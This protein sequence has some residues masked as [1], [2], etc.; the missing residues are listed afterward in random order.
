MPAAST[1]T[2]A[3]RSA[4]SPAFLTGWTSFVAGFSGAIAAVALVLPF[5]LARFTPAAGN[6][7]PFF[8]I[9]IVPGAIA[10]SFS[11]QTV[12][13]LA[14][15]SGL[16]FVHL[17]GVGPGRFVSNLLATLKV[18]AFVLFI[19]W[20]FGVGTGNAANIAETAAPVT[21][22]GWLL[23]LM[24]V[25]FTYSGWNAAAYMA[26]EIRDPGRN[27]PRALA[28]GTGAVDRHL[29]ADERP[30][31]LRGAG[32]RARDARGQRA[33]RRRR[34]PDRADGRQHHG[35]RGIISLAASVSA[36]TFAG[37]RVYF[38]MARDGLFFTRAA[39]VHATYKT[40]AF[41]IL[42]QTAWASLLVLTAQADR[43]STTR[44][45]RSGCSRGW[46]WRRLFVLR[47][48]EP[49]ADRPFRTWGYPVVPA[50]YALVAAIV[51]VN[52]LIRRSR[53]D[54]RRCDW[55]SSRASRS[56]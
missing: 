56:I 48:R 52:G 35:H 55:S 39:S 40:P 37:P 23:A 20:G 17:R 1:S 15:I 30:V 27:V 42:A 54:R 7:T 36:M 34:S 16:A 29:P 25:G 5:Y 19:A 43:L 11:A 53:T 44:A 31:P 12:I 38:A 24:A 28:L 22:A 41:S 8:S 6:T 13:A 50:L 10:L 21:G 47:R 33:R 18:L 9:P 49:N 3:T 14:L 2:C 46:R 26:E 45:L 4:R 51:I 32:R